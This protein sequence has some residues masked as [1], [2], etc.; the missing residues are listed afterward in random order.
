MR[1]NK[2]MGK[3]THKCPCGHELDEVVEYVWLCRNK[4]WPHIW[5]GNPGILMS[6]RVSIQKVIKMAQEI[7][8]LRASVA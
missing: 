1:L 4:K 8:E 3:S 5:A 6:E 7:L 2:A